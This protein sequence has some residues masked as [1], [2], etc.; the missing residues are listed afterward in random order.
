ML[1]VVVVVPEL[2]YKRSAL[3]RAI[4]DFCTLQLTM[5]GSLR[6]PRAVPASY[7][8]MEA[9]AVAAVFDSSRHRRIKSPH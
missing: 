4:G 6:N 9:N 7:E 8:S 2:L 5:R 1:V 3:S